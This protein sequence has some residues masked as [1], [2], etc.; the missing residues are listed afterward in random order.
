MPPHLYRRLSLLFFL[1][2]FTWGG[3]FVTLGNYLMHG[4]AFGGREIG[5]VYS[6]SALAATVTPFLLG[7]LAD[8]FFA[9][10]RLLSLLFLAAGLTLAALS[11]LD[12]FA[13]F[14]PV[15]ILQCLVFVPT[16]SLNNALAFYHLDTPQQQFPRIRVWGTIGWIVAGVIISAFGLEPTAYPMRMAAA[17][18]LA[19][20][21]YCRTLPYTP[22]QPEVRE[23]KLRG[24]FGPEVRA[25]LRRRSFALLVACLALISIPASFYYSFVNPYMT[26]LG[27]RYPAGKMALGQV[28][29][30]FIMLLLPFFFTRLGVRW[31]IGIGFLAW[32]TRYALFAFGQTPG[33][34]WMIYLGILLHGVAF[35]FSVLTSQIYVDQQVPRHVRS[36]AQ[37]FVAFL[38]LGVGAL[39]GAY[40]AGEIV[41][42]FTLADNTHRWGYIFGIPAGVGILAAVVFMVFFRER[43]QE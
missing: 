43:G 37:G 28:T 40:L 4:L 36:T 29:E 8:R 30:I 2:F 6:S 3:W 15:M 32:G 12:T 42:Y 35:N 22:P 10:E 1:Q 39:V 23:N 38:T 14:Y 33:L 13:W 9:I 25:L 27:I 17:G 26:E 5:L 7:L 34:N 19:L 31:M 21:L 20:A 41:E 11:L 16:L 24:F 18:N